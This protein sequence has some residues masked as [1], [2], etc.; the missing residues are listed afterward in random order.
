M[1]SGWKKCGYGKHIIL[2]QAKQ[3]LDLLQSVSSSQPEINIVKDQ[4]LVLV[5][6]KIW[7]SQTHLNND[8]IFNR[9][10]VMEKIRKA[11]DDS[12][13]CNTYKWIYWIEEP[14]MPEVEYKDGLYNLLKNT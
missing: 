4:S 6:K 12:C 10:L 14:A 9:M 3:V 13:S 7:M 2:G 1:H 11:V 8:R 5:K